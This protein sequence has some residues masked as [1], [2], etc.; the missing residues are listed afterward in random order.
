MN[1]ILY[2][3]ND[4]SLIDLTRS[5]F[6]KLISSNETNLII[7]RNEKDSLEQ[8]T[9]NYSKIIFETKLPYSN[10]FIETLKYKYLNNK[11]S[12]YKIVHSNDGNPNLEIV[13]S[14]LM[15]NHLQRTRPF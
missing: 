12:I 10:E 3:G 1:K 8:L 6:L 15:L 11:N 14:P 2:I 5:K 13:S 4:E 9:K 7:A